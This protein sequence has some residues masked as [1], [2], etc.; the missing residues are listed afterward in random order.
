MRYYD[1]TNGQ[2]LLTGHDTRSLNLAWLRSQI[3][4]VSQEPQLFT[5]SIFENVAYGL[6]GTPYELP[7]NPSELQI[8]DAR[9]RVEWA[10]KQA[11]AWDFVCNLPEG[12]NTRVS[13]GR[14]G[15]LSGGQRQRIAA[16]RALVRRPRILL[17]DEGTS[18]LD[19]ETEH[20]LMKAIHKEQEET[21]M[22]TM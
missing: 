12:V 22:T 15:V 13:G 2:L 1:P 21:G 20:N 10:L 5:A 14:T 8:E 4:L 18:A 7:S 16:A 3:S 17:L 9:R 6:T 11:Q 19:S